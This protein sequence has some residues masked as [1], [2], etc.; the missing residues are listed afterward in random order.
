MDDA[1]QAMLREL[2]AGF[3]RVENMTGLVLTT[4]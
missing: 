3:P 4:R 2:D 1:V